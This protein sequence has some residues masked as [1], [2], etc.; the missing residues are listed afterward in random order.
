MWI[1][2]LSDTL[3]FLFFRYFSSILYGCL[4]PVGK[5]NVITSVGPDASVSLGIGVGWSDEGPIAGLVAWVVHGTPVGEAAWEVPALGELVEGAAGDDVT[6]PRTDGPDE[7]CAGSE[8]SDL[9]SS[10]SR[11]A[12]MSCN[13]SGLGALGRGSSLL[14][15]SGVEEVGVL[16]IGCGGSRWVLGMSVAPLDPWV[17]I[18]SPLGLIEA[19][20]WSDDLWTVTIAKAS[21]RK[22]CQRSL[23]RVMIVAQCFKGSVAFAWVLNG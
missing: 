15:S 12:A 2:L 18:S 16:C 3:T 23:T 21:S 11:S 1:G 20:L 6:A 14:I 19:I 7:D 9:E 17:R 4:A 13:F 10:P 8:G 22:G 5:S